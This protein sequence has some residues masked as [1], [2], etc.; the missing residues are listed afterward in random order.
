MNEQWIKERCETLRIK[1]EAKTG[2]SWEVLETTTAKGRTILVATN[3]PC[4]FCSPCIVFDEY[5]RTYSQPNEKTLYEIE[6]QGISASQRF[7]DML[8]DS[9]ELWA[10]FAAVECGRE[11]VYCPLGGNKNEHGPKIYELIGLEENEFKKKLA[12]VFA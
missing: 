12:E 4:F 11:S 9:Y 2:I 1:L 10:K 6:L 3:E 7:I 8:I 5:Y